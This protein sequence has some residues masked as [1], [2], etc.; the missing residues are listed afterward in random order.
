MRAGEQE[1]GS[2]IWANL[3]PFGGGMDSLTLS[4][5]LPEEAKVSSSADGTMDLGIRLLVEGM[6]EWISLSC[7]S[8]TNGVKISLERTAYNKMGGRSPDLGGQQ[9]P[10]RLYIYLLTE[11][12]S[13]LPGPVEPVW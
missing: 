9:C 7:Q 11:E 13:C 12:M 6:K 5:D 8:W 10:H 4:S 3:L 1:S 2:S